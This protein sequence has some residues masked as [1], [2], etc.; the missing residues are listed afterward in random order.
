ME[1]KEKG[2]K[3]ESDKPF[4]GSMG[5]FLSRRTT[6]PGEMVLL[7]NGQKKRLKEE[8]IE[9]YKHIIN[10]FHS[11]LVEVLFILLD[12]CWWFRPRDIHAGGRLTKGNSKKKLFKKKKKKPPKKNVNLTIFPKAGFRVIWPILA[13]YWLNTG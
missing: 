5:L 8:R 10:I 4:V 9:K 11:Q 12:M 1:G 7:R 13:I 3:Y 6:E 2:N